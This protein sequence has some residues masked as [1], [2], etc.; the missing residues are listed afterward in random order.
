MDTDL[1]SLATAL[2]VTTDDLLRANPER[3]PARPRIGILPG[4]TD[5]EM[6][7]LVVVQAPLGFNN[8]TQWLRY[9]HKN[10]L[11]MFPTLPLPS[12]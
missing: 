8:E 4:T 10:L 3:V 1:D 2:Y 6:L 11:A 12:G 5:A 9:A 7:T